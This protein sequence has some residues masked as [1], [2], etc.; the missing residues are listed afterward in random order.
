MAES[1][2]FVLPSRTDPQ[3][4]ESEGTPTVLVEAQACG[5]PVISTI[6]ADIPSI[7]ADGD[8]GLLVP[9]GQVEALRDALDRLLSQPARWATM[10]AAGRAYVERRHSPQAVGA[11]LEQL[12]DRALR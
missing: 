2:L 8:A 11:Q 6:H 7:V 10:G 9:E 12:Y 4:G 3:T 1:D 5:L